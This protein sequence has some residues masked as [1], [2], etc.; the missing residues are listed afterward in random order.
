MLGFSDEE[1]Q[2]IGIAQQGSGKGV[3]QGVLGLPGRL[4]GGIFGG[5]STTSNMTPNNQVHTRLIFIFQDA[6]YL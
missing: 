4:V 3:I 6:T 2:R 5:G 1:K